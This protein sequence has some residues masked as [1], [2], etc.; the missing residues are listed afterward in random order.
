MKRLICALFF[1]VG[2]SYGAVVNSPSDLAP[3]VVTVSKLSSSGAAVGAIYHASA[4][5]AVSWLAAPA[6]GRLLGSQGVGVAP[7]WLTDPSVNSLTVT[8]TTGLFVTGT[9]NASATEALLQVGAAPVGGSSNGHMVN[10]NAPSGFTG[11]LMRAQVNGGTNVWNVNSSGG[12]YFASSVGFGVGNPVATVNIDQADPT[13]TTEKAAFRQESFTQTLGT[14]TTLTT[15]RGAIYLHPVFTA[16]GAG[17][18][19]TNAATLYVDQGPSASSAGGFTP[20][21]TNSYAFWVDSGTTALDGP[22]IAGS[23]LTVTG[24]TTHNGAV[25]NAA[26]TNLTGVSGSGDRMVYIQNS[27]GL[28][29]PVT[30]GSNLNFS[31]GTL[32][33]TG[34]SGT[35]LPLAGGTMSGTI[36]SNHIKPAS[37]IG[38]TLGDSTHRYLSAYTRDMYIASPGGTPSLYFWDTASDVIANPQFV[39]TTTYPGVGR[40][41]FQGDDSGAGGYKDRLTLPAQT[42]DGAVLMYADDGLEVK[43]EAGTSNGD[44]KANNLIS[45]VAGS[46]LKIKEGSNAKMGTATLVGG[47]VTV[48]TTAVTANS[49]I[50]LTTQT[51]GGTIGVQYIS[52]RSAGT[53][54]TITS[55]SG[56]DTSTVAWLIVEPS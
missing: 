42:S 23:T 11:N 34:I 51:L 28:V 56:T 1:I 24:A 20:T 18:V 50:F 14:S 36:T 44:V 46:G 8:G 22:I 39:I 17:S 47:T 32:S 13:A 40:L 43:D 15:A 45:N 53:S 38:Y 6:T 29:A 2:S 10:I 54:F 25:T 27:T 7:A 5:N 4:S 21:I 30:P 35:Y 52:A 16:S 26:A 48:N 12:G 49:R 19:V 33:V 31:G 41:R 3:K 55:A 37:D 9:P